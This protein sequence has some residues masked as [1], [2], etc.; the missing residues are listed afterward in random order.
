MKIDGTLIIAVPNCASD[1]AKH[2]GSYWAAY[3][4]PRHLWHFTRKDM[5]ALTGQYGFDLIDIRPMPWDAYY[6][7]LLSEKYLKNSL[8]MIRGAWRG[9]LSNLAAQG[10]P[11]KS[12]SIIYILK[13]KQ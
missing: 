8:P 6:V 5:A 11:E 9:F 10:R 1:D 2:Y 3:D 13:K 4:V 7:S 12:S